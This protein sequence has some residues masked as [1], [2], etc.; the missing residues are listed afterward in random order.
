MKATQGKADAIIRSPLAEEWNY[1]GAM[2]IEHAAPSPH[3]HRRVKVT[4]VDVAETAFIT[5]VFCFLVFFVFRFGESQSLRYLDE[6]IPSA[7]LTA[8]Q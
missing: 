3:R 8:E 1:D 7:S 4:A 6:Q 5:V 2:N